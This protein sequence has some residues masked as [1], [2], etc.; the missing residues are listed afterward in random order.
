MQF[1]NLKASEL[2]GQVELPG[3]AEWVNSLSGQETAL[4]ITAPAGT[5]KTAAVGM[6]ARKLE[7]DVM[8]C[9]LLQ[10][11]EYPD[12]RDVLRN[13]LTIAANLRSL[14]FLAEGLDR[15]LERFQK[16][17]DSG[18]AEEISNWL[19]DK[20][21]RMHSYG[22]TFVATGRTMNTVPQ[23]LRAQFDNAFSLEE[24]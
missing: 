10:V 14:V 20:K 24:K 15:L 1:K 7:R 2:D 18:V 22:V 3:L 17:G 6:I 16:A 12:S 19:A 11:F 21:D 8:A 5:G 9:D 4:L 13:I 23:E